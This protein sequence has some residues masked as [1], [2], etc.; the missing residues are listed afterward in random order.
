M[1]LEPLP[2]KLH[3]LLAFLL[4]KKKFFIAT[5]ISN[6]PFPP[7]SPRK[8]G[9]LSLLHFYN[10][11]WPIIL[12]VRDC[13]VAQ[14]CSCCSVW[15]LFIPLTDKKRYPNKDNCTVL[16]VLLNTLLWLRVTQQRVSLSHTES[17]FSVR[18]LSTYAI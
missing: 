1:S 5:I 4:M 18:N 2:S 9:S 16:T 10:C 11:F 6:C 13:L 8:Q 7:T 15:M 14:Q 3:S 17:S 12:L